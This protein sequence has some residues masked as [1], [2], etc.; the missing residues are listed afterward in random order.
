MELKVY[1]M[2][3]WNRYWLSLLCKLNGFMNAIVRY[4]LRYKNPTG[5]H[6]F[7]G[8]EVKKKTPMISCF[9]KIFKWKEDKKKL[10]GK[11]P[12]K[13]NLQWRRQQRLY[14]TTGYNIKQH[15]LRIKD[16]GTHKNTPNTFTHHTHAQCARCTPSQKKK[17]IWKTKANTHRYGAFIY[18]FGLRL[19][20]YKIIIATEDEQRR[21]VVRKYS[22]M[23]AW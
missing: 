6:W 13:L 15:K 16:K 5:I 7:H 9:W 2:H 18:L 11:Y 10:L 8:T 22:G 21:K 1:S 17:K 23:S 4:E 3:T 12:Y 20:F 19:W 14:Q